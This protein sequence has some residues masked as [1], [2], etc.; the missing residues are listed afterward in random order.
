MK[1]MTSVVIFFYL[2]VV[3]FLEK[4]ISLLANKETKLNVFINSIHSKTANIYRRVCCNCNVL[5]T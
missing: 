5:S 3:V 4:C 2:Q 1:I